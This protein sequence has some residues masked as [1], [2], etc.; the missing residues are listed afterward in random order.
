MFSNFL[1][2]YTS[3]QNSSPLNLSNYLYHLHSLTY[4]PD[5][6]NKPADN[7]TK[8]AALDMDTLFFKPKGISKG[9]LFSVRQSLLKEWGPDSLGVLPEDI[10]QELLTGETF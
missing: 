10:I 4:A 3:H 1:H 7:L 9:V 6:D 8:L 2:F 5:A